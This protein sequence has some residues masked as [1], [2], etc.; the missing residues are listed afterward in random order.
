MEMVNTSETEANDA[1]ISS[2]L[3]GYKKMMCQELDWKLGIFEGEQFILFDMDFPHCKVEI[4]TPC[5][6]K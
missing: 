2:T 3:N 5:L 1:Y 4:K 6:Q